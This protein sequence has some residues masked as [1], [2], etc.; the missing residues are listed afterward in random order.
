MK[1]EDIPIRDPFVFA[2]NGVYYL[3]G[4]TRG[5]KAATLRCMRRRI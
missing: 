2:E 1:R 4:T 3:L 5:G